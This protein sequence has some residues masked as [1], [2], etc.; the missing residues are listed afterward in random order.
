[1]KSRKPEIYYFR[2]KVWRSIS[3]CNPANASICQEK[4]MEFWHTLEESYQK[5]TS[6]S[7]G[8]LM[9]NNVLCAVGGQVLSTCGLSS[10]ENL[11]CRDGPTSKYNITIAQTF[12]IKLTFQDH[13]RHS[14][15]TTSQIS[16]VT[17]TLLRLI[18]LNLHSNNGLP[19]RQN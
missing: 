13:S 9:L 18:S 6:L 16:I 15:I 5:M 3:F 19:W 2:K 4:L 12:Y 1:M 17:S 7:L 10:E 14:L 8:R 11:R